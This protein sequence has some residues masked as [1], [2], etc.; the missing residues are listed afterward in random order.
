MKDVDS[1]TAAVRLFALVG[2]VFPPSIPPPSF[3][4]A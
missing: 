2:M 1:T 4:I 3:T